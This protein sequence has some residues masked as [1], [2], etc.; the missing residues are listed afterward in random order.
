MRLTFK[1]AVWNYAHGL[2]YPACAN[3]SIYFSLAKILDTVTLD[4]LSFVVLESLL[5][6][7]N[8]SY[9]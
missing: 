7:K 3:F 2:V 6:N 8:K 9:H 5:Q 1:A 4:I